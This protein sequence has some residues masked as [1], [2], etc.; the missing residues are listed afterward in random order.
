MPKIKKKTKSSNVLK[1][2]FTETLKISG[3]V[4]T[5]LFMIVSIYKYDQNHFVF[6][7]SFIFN[8]VNSEALICMRKPNFVGF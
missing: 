4:W 3:F 8:S 1:F 2:S 7:I 5:R 6:L